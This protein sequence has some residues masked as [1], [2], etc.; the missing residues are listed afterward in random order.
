MTTLAFANPD[1]APAIARLVARPLPGPVRLSLSC[2]PAR[3]HD[4][5]HAIVARDARGTI[6]GHGARTVRQLRLDGRPRWVGYLHGLRRDEAAAGAGRA[7]MRGLAAL[8]ATRRGDE[9]DHDFTAI[10]ADNPHARRVLEGLPGAARYHRIAAYRTA[11]LCAART[12]AAQI[13]GAMSAASGDAAGIEALVEAHA[14]DYAPPPCVSTPGDWFI[15]HRAGRL[16]GCVQ[17][18]AGPDTTRVDGY[19]GPLAHLRPL[20]NLAST[21]LRRPTLPPAG[22]TLAMAYAAHLTVPDGDA[23]DVRALLG[24]AARAACARGRRLLIVGLGSCHPLVGIVAR[25]PAWRS[26]S[27]I[28][29]VGAEPPRTSRFISPEAWLL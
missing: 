29:A 18:V 15:L 25:L 5:H 26:E 3:A 11:V 23:R 14:G 9:A 13:D 12:A 21:L 20:A 4:R 10:L 6:V 16:A 2:T 22:T 8:A 27:L 28:Y 1:D 7:L 17:V 24:A 19:S